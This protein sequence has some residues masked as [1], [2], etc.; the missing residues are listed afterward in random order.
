MKNPHNF[1]IEALEDSEVLLISKKNK[2]FAYSN[3]PK[4]EK[5]FRAITKKKHVSL[6][7]R[8]IDNLSKTVELRYIEFTEKHPQLI[9][10]F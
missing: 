3:L 4:T 1:F 2:E 9:Q 8:R 7:R 10:Q 6:Q 5:L